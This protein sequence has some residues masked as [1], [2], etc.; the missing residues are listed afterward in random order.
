MFRLA[1]AIRV[2]VTIAAAPLVS[3]AGGA[4]IYVKHDAAGAD[5]GTSW[6]NAYRSLRTALNAAASGDEVWVA[7]GTYV[8]ATVADPLARDRVF[9]VK[10]G[11]K[12]YGGFAGTE[13]SRAQ[14]NPAANITT[15]SGDIAGN[16]T[17]G[18]GNR[19]DNSINIVKVIGATQPT[20]IDGLTIREANIHD[21]NVVFEFGGALAI[22]ESVNVHVRNCVIRDNDGQSGSA[23]SIVFCMDA[24]A[25]TLA[26]CLIAGNRSDGACIE[27]DHTPNL[28]F[29]AC[30]IAGNSTPSTDPAGMILYDCDL[31]M[32]NSILWGNS[33]SNGQGQ[34]AAIGAYF[35][36]ELDVS[37]TNVQGAA[38]GFGEGCV[39]REPCFAD[40]AGGDGVIGT[41]DDDFSLRR[42]STMIDAGDGTRLLFD[43]TDTDGNGISL[44]VL[45]RDLA[46]APREHDDPGMLG[47]SFSPYADMGAYE[48]QGSSCPGDVDGN[49][50][51]N[52]ADLTRFLANFGLAVELCSATDLN[53][54][55]VVNTNDL[56]LL[57][58]KFGLVCP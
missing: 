38:V 46:F 30:T 24:A 8:P 20:F 7:R 47:A 3:A 11:V 32:A 36:S 54:D 19:A 23:V 41:G 4:T 45:P 33:N 28:Y 49:G 22:V 14:R 12:L 17:P 25:I 10:S 58:S 9:G 57:L 2:S 37:Y 55:G 39:T 34:D 42:G 16:D 50:V 13:A 6:A 29:N 56:V 18:G 26:N 27:A 15:L 44:E 5:N 35:N 43:T 52:T 31:K 21:D 1:N 53:H 40:P 48:F 51:I